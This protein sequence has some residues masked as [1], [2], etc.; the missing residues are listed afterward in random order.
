MTEPPEPSPASAPAAPADA[1]ELREKIIRNLKTVYDP[2]IPV[3]IWELGLVYGIDIAG[4]KS[5]K[6]SMTLTSPNCP[7]AEQIPVDVEKKAR[8]VE[9]V[10]D[11]AVEVVWEPAWNKD[12]MSEDAKL[13]LGVE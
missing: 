3:D 1:A 2:E 9:G 7:S 4:D 11:V 12:K 10:K 8:A 5:V 6:I 13:A